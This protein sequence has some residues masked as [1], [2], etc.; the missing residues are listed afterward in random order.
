MQALHPP[1]KLLNVL[2]L[3]PLLDGAADFLDKPHIGKS[4]N[5]FEGVE[6]EMGLTFLSLH[7]FPVGVGEGLGFGVFFG[8]CWFPGQFEH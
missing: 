2:L 1:R 5:S 6:E 3:R 7:G 4:I 8:K